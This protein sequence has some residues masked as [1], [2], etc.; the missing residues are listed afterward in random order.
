ML[1]MSLVDVAVIAPAA[2]VIGVLIGYV[3]H[4]RY[5]KGDD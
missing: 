3:L 5:G 2:L 4:A 1:Y